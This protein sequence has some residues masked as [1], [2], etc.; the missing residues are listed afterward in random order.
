MNA[1]ATHTLDVLNAI[2][3]RAL[4][5]RAR[6]GSIEL[7]PIELEGRTY[8]VRP[9][10][11]IAISEWGL[12]VNLRCTRAG[13]PPLDGEVTIA[14]AESW[15]DVRVPAFV[16]GW[17]GA[18][19]AILESA[20]SESIDRWVPSYLDPG[21]PVDAMEEG[22]N[23]EEFCRKFLEYTWLGYLLP[24]RPKVAPMFERAPRSVA[25]KA[26]EIDLYGLWGWIGNFARRC[27]VDPRW[28]DA[29]IQRL[30]PAARALEGA[31]MI[32]AMV[33]GN[34]FEVF[35]ASQ[36]SAVILHCYESLSAIGAKQLSA[37]MR[38]G[39]GL[40]ARQGA[41]FTTERN[42][43]WLR[44]F[45]ADAA[46]QWSDVDGHDPGRSYA[47]M[48]SELVPCANAFAERNRDDLVRT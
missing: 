29:L 16:E 24:K 41:E 21:L 3:A 38:R 10:G 22:T 12:S 5:V 20:T 7:A 14:H 23:S 6:H 18:V 2:L 19:K 48:T 42:Q 45:R 15:D 46:E 28:D 40:A 32:D 8:P 34:G 13:R 39:V 25:L 26:S 31:Q 37:L 35:L 47:L 43:G 1:P 44:P 17:L 30:P 4:P 11:S 27:Y 36:R 33:G 9:V